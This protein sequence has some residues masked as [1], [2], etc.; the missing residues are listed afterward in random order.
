LLYPWPLSISN[1][2]SLLFWLYNPSL[3]L[4]NHTI[5]NLWCSATISNFCELNSISWLR[6]P[7]NNPVYHYLRSSD[8]IWAQ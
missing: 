7:A 3:C 1:S 5:L 6:F 2:V 4:C 8:A